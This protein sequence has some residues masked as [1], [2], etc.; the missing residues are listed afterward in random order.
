MDFKINTYKEIKKEKTEEK[1]VKNIEPKIEDTNFK[2]N[3]YNPDVE[4]E[5]SKK[6]EEGKP[7]ESPRHQKM[8]DEPNYWGKQ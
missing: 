8:G 1:P 2:V 4:T 7:S 5:D 3:S 6:P